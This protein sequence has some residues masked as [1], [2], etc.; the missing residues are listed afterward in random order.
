MTYQDSG[1]NIDSGNNLISA[2]NPILTLPYGRC[3]LKTW[4]VRRRI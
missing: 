2:I 3:K 4:R 1:V